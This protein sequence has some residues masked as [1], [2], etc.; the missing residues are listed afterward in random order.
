MQQFAT[1]DVRTLNHRLRLQPR[2][3]RHLVLR[4]RPVFTILSLVLQFVTITC[5]QRPIACSEQ[6]QLQVLCQ[7]F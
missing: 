5:K 4:V 7:F 1:A 6:A 3:S 2:A